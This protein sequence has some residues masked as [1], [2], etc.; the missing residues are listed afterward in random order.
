MSIE[1]SRISKVLMII[2]L[3]GSLAFL[4]GCDQ[5]EGDD[6]PP[7]PQGEQG[8]AGQDVDPVVADNLQSQIDELT[9][10][11]AA[12]NNV[13]PEQCVICHEGFGAS[14]HQDIYDD[15]TDASNL[16]FTINSVVSV[17][18]PDLTT[19]TSTVN[20]TIT[21]NGV[22][23]NDTDADADG[24]LDGLD[25]HRIAAAI[26][27][28]TTGDY[29]GT[30]GNY[31]DDALRVIGG[32]VY[33]SDSAK[34]PFA[35]ELGNGQ[36]Y[37]YI[38]MD[39]LD[40]EQSASSHVHLYADM[41]DDAIAW[42]DADSADPDAYVSAA[43]PEGCEK[44]HGS[45]YLKHGY[46]AAEVAPLP[47]F[48]ACK[49]CHFDDRDGGHEDWQIL[50]DN[51]VR[52]AE[53]YN[54]ADLTTEEETYYAYKA[55]LM[56][57]V[58][59]AHAMEFPYPQSMANCA[60]C[61]EGKLDMIINDDQFTEE[62]CRSCHPV[63]GPA[64]GTDPHRAPAL[65]TLWEEAGVEAFHEVGLDC[66][67]CHMAG[68]VA[69]QFTDKHTGYDPVIYTAGGVRYSD[70]FTVTIDSASL[71]DNT[72]NIKFSATE[73]AGN[74]VAAVDVD[75]I[76][77]TIFVGM[78][79]YDTFQYLVGPHDRDEN[80]NRLLELDLD[81]ESTNPRFEVVDTGVAGSWEVNVD[82]SMWADMIAGDEID[83]AEIGVTADLREVV[84]ERDSR[85]NGESD[86]V[87]YG[88]EAPS[89][90]FDLD[91]NVFDDDYFDDIVN[92]QV[93]ATTRGCDDCHDLLATTFHSPTRRGNI[94][95]CKMCHV[96]S[97][98]GSHME[99][100]SRDI[101]NYVHA[102]H[103]FQAFDSGD[104]DF[105]DPVEAVRYELHTNHT[106]PNFTIKNCEACHNPGT[107]DVPSQAKSLPRVLAATDDWTTA[108]RTIGD[109]P[110]SVTGP[111]SSTCGACH[112]AEFLNADDGGSL[113]AFIQHTNEFGYYIE[114]DDGVWETVIENIMPMF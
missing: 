87:M 15:Y 86:D 42:G 68:G 34:L 91:N 113:A 39:A 106:F 108:D 3:V 12:A 92:V 29:E 98:R 52:F 51:P 32:G 111:A 33:E 37:G 80:R 99:L 53:I 45:P 25:Q 35:P 64:G 90:T 54:G 62:T 76:L 97:S 63:T 107:Y 94:R 44:C 83:R 85:S 55:K 67:G 14:R 22:A 50:V 49:V 73:D 7:G 112:R 56:N 75:D 41:A 40:I 8:P 57:D 74:P 13:E 18:N 48:G 31:Y 89:R 71:T 60:T 95:I 11:Q 109:I 23:Y 26:Y 81:G 2:S 59:M 19:Y 43:N 6:G 105:T 103:S 17:L 65:M 38:A 61:H 93:D 84:G 69:K 114:D 9:A 104:V 100:Q 46:R 24:A 70:I 58:H 21:Q 96:P 110:Q 16:T 82:L 27:N 36:V 72:L 88:M 102:I 47:D 101:S 79:G 1:I 30:R 10:A 66:N 20:Y 4:S 78:Y 77:P 28:A 5:L